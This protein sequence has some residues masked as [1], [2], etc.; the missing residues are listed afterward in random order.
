[1]WD[2]KFNWLITRVQNSLN[3]QVQHWISFQYEFPLGNKNYQIYVYSN[4]LSK[5]VVV[6][7]QSVYPV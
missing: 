2:L 3:S 5:N 4:M 7:C 6:T 1:M